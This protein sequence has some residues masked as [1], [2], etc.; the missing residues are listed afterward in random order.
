MASPRELSYVDIVGIRRIVYIEA[1]ENRRCFFG[2][3]RAA[4]RTHSMLADLQ[5]CFRGRYRRIMVCGDWPFLAK[6]KKDSRRMMRI[7][8][9]W[10]WREL[11]KDEESR[12]W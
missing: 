9:I 5:E 3:D 4:I 11:E 7:L 1:R 10:G 8:G 2:D 6:G 12:R